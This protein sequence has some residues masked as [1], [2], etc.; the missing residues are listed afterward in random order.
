MRNFNESY[1]KSASLTRWTFPFLVNSFYDPTQNSIVVPVAALIQ[2]YLHN[3]LP[4]YISYGMIGMVFSHGILHAF[5]LIGTEYDENG[6][7][8]AWMLPDT[9]L[10]LQA[11]LECIVKQHSTVLRK[12]ADF[13][14]STGDVPFEWNVT[15]NEH[16][17]DISGLHVAYE[18]WH[19][20]QKTHPDPRLSGLNLSPSQLFFLHS[21][22]V[23]CSNI[24][25]KD[26]VI[27]VQQD[28]YHH[29]SER[30]NS[31]MMNSVEFAESFSCTAGRKMNPSKKCSL[32]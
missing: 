26:D 15:R 6:S 30:V 24:P 29:S 21:G 25:S 22:Q 3:N 1:Y 14:S 18:T 5:D 11:R 27:Y 19:N 10:R 17:A 13:M 23:L 20:L 32:F 2:P 9:K 12:E 28:F 16:M 31:I 8:I 4:E 7:K